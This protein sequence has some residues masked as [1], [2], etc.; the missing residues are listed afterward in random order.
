MEP[1]EASLK[2]CAQQ[3]TH[4]LKSS[5]DHDIEFDTTL[6]FSLPCCV[7][8]DYW[9]KYRMSENDVMTIMETVPA[10]YCWLAVMLHN[11]RM[12]ASAISPSHATKYDTLVSSKIIAIRK[13]IN[14]KIFMDSEKT[15]LSISKVY[16][17][18]IPYKNVSHD[19][20]DT[21]LKNTV[22]TINVFLVK[23]V[24][25]V[26][27]DG[28]DKWLPRHQEEHGIVCQA[29]LSLVEFQ[30]KFRHPVELPLSQRPMIVEYQHEQFVLTSEYVTMRTA[31]TS[32]T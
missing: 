32:D 21:L 8:P 24:D 26:F 17:P 7:L 15:N 27:I 29:L 23:G 25:F 6:M 10:K 22:P 30:T 4:Y 28:D 2:G 16:C 5:S 14:G 3:R 20:M 18:P 13:L 1:Y 19:V 12:S 9:N 31:T 11:Q